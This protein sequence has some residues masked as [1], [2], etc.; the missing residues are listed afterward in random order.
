MGIAEIGFYFCLRFR[1]NFFRHTDFL[2]FKISKKI[3]FLNSDF[4][5]HR[6]IFS[7][8]CFFFGLK[9]QKKCVSPIMLKI[10]LVFVKNVFFSLKK[11]ISGLA[12]RV[13]QKHTA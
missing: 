10:T 3:F 7:F 11:S 6:K 2:R 4:R 13:A 12:G 1:H 5:Y 8:F 9:V